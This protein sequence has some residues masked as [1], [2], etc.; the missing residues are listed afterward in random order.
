[1][2]SNKRSGARRGRDPETSG[3]AVSLPLDTPPMEARSADELPLG[4]GW[5]FEPKWDG[6]RCLAFKA[7]DNVETQG[8]IRQAAGSVLS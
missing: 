3:S 6:F 7:G 5:Q 8:E 1:M 4:T 2:S